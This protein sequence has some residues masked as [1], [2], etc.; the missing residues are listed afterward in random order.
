MSFD[1]DSLPDPQDY[2]ENTA[3]L[4]LSGRGAWRTTSCEFHGGGDSMRIN[5]KSGGF[6]CMNCQAK[7]GDVLAYEMKSSGIEFL[8]AAKA[9]GAWTDDGRHTTY[10]PSPVSARTML[11]VIGIEVQIVALIAS[12]LCNGK[13]ISDVDRVR[14]M[15]S[16]SRIARVA[17][18]VQLG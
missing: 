3:A 2:Y 6:M 4:K 5:L 13:A 9:L 17:E 7:G 15:L 16:V 11:K 12:D 10:R 18:E 1:K 14:L 8:D